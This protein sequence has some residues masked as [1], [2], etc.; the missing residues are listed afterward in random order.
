M[1]N[2]ARDAR[3]LARLLHLGQIVEVSVPSVEQER[4]GICSAPEKTVVAI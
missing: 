1:K 3:H 4:P 2:D